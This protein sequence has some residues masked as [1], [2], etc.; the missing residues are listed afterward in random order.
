M[1]ISIFRFFNLLSSFGVC[2]VPVSYQ[3]ILSKQLLFDIFFYTYSTKH[4]DDV[5]NCHQWVTPYLRLKIEPA[6][7]KRS[8]ENL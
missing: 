8:K 5:E 2:L 6:R 4:S 1:F 7:Q 3:I